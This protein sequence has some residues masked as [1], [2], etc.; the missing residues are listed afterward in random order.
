VF[1][2]S[3]QGMYLYLD[4][5]H[6]A[7]N[8]LFATWLGYKS[9]AAWAASKT[10]FAKLFVDEKSARTLVKAYQNAMERAVASVVPVSWKSKSGKKVKTQVILVPLAHKDIEYALHFVTK[11]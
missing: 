8:K 4:D 6:K 3:D 9:P 7:C 11:K 5:H 2:A 10:P 1:D